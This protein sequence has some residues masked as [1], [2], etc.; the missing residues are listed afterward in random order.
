[1]EYRAQEYAAAVL[2]GEQVACRQ[3]VQA[4]RRY[5]DDLEHGEERGLWFD[6]RAAQ[7]AIVFFQVVHHWK[8]EWA[9][10]PIVLEPW[11]Q[12]M[13]W[14]VFGWKREDGTRRFRTAYLEV[15]RKNGKTTLAAGIGLF[16]MLADGEP[17]AEIYTAAT[18][19][20]QAR[21]AHRDATQMVKNSPSLARLANVVRDNIHAT[22][23]A[24]KFE[25][26]GRDSSSLDGLNVHAAICDEVHAWKGRGMWDV[27]ETATGSRRQPLMMAITTAGYD[28]SSFCWGMHEYT[29]K[30]LE[31]TVEDDSH[32][33]MIFS[34]DPD[35]DWEDEAV[36]VK[37]NPN[38]EVSKKVDDMRRLKGRA[39]EMPAALNAFLRLHLNKWTQAAER[40]IDPE[41][42]AACGEVGVESSELRGRTC[43]GGLDLGSTTD[44]N[45]WVLVFPPLPQ[46]VDEVPSASKYAADLGRLG[47][48]TLA[49]L[50]I[51]DLEVLTSIK[52]V[53][54]VTAERWKEEA[55]ALLEPYQVLC[56]FWVPD[57]SMQER[58]KRDRVPYEAWVR[59]GYMRTTPG[60]VTDLQELGFTVDQKTHQQT[61]APLLIQFGQ[62]FA[63]MAGPTKEL[64]RLIKTKGIAHGDHP[65][66]N[67]MA[68]NVMVRQDPAGNLKPDKEK[69][70]EKIDGIV[71]LIMGL[72]RA[73]VHGQ[74]KSV[75]AD[76]GLRE[77]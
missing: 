42:W 31:G 36:W 68:G 20:D 11:Q 65:A 19:R 7:L 22:A 1:M 34:L 38:L 49:G 28:R 3:V 26:L 46:S 50:A 30:V 40:W 64:E 67:W 24:S 53:G 76:R 73:M 45:A 9:G 21:I 41:K 32:F 29:E 48:A 55:R 60:N 43:Y 16:L 33:G 6:E 75:Y 2:N 72:A 10:Q 77:L 12:F 70:T 74:T 57:E 35:D 17:G 51:A 15:A 63:S 23:T 47:I 8:G 58:V 37:A 13:V 71:A 4:C 54:K 39:E 25:P 69:S 44:I 27:L 5:L 59:G 52:D 18:K 66:L 14:N 62:G 61:G 56:R